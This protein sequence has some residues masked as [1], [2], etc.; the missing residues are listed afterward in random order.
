MSE[1]DNMKMWD[2]LTKEQQKCLIQLVK[3]LYK[4]IND[5]VVKPLLEMID[6]LSFFFMALEGHWR[7]QI[8]NAKKAGKFTCSCKPGYFCKTC[9]NPE[10][11]I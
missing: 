6:D 4:V 11:F 10:N 8:F 3:D 2:E 1:T 5:G 7:E 9:T